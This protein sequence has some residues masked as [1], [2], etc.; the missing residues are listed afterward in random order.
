MCPLLY[1]RIPIAQ[2]PPSRA[3]CVTRRCSTVLPQPHTPPHAPS[4]TSPT[5]RCRTPM[6]PPATWRPCT[7]NNPAKPCSPLCA[8]PHP[9]VQGQG[10]SAARRAPGRPGGDGAQG[11][12]AHDRRRPKGGC[13]RSIYVG[14]CAAPPTLT[15]SPLVGRAFSRMWVLLEAPCQVPG[16]V[17]GGFDRW[18]TRGLSAPYAARPTCRRRLATCASAAAW[19]PPPSAPTRWGPLLVL[20]LSGPSPAHAACPTPLCKHAPPHRCTGRVARL[21]AR[22]QQVAPPASS[23][24]RQVRTALLL[25]GFPSSVPAYT[26]NR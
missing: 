23:P 12:A 14:R 11:P 20:P 10:G 15:A 1:S 17:R 25:A 5:R 21:S 16:M 19:A 2:P 3:T 13:W 4:R 24:A 22:A 8:G 18:S 26:V 9:H 7:P 6:R